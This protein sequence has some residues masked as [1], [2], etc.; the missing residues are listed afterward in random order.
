MVYKK[1]LELIKKDLKFPAIFNYLN[2]KARILSGISAFI[3]YL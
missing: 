1:G 2:L 3:N